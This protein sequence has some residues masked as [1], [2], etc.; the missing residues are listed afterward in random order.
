VRFY[1]LI[2]S[3][4][5]AAPVYA[6]LEVVRAFPKAH[7][8]DA[9]ID[10]PIRV[11]FDRP[12]N[13]DDLSFIRVWSDFSGELDGVYTLEA[14][15]RLA[16]FTP[17]DLLH[18]GEP[19]TVEISHH[20]RAAD[21]STMRPEGY[22]YRFCAISAPSTMEFEPEEVYSVRSDPDTLVRLYG[23]R[24]VDLNKDRRIDIL[25]VNEVS[26]DVR[27]LLNNPSPSGT[28]EPFIAPTNPTGSTPSPNI[29]G[30]FNDD[31]EIDFVTCNTGADTL[32]V[33]FGNGD[34]SFGSSI[35]LWVGNGPRGV[36]A[37]D[38]DGDNDTDIIA[39]ATAASHVAVLINT[40]SGNFAPAVTFDGG[41]NREFGLAGQDMNGDG[42]L[43][44]V[45]GIWTP[46]AV[47]VMLGNGDGTFTLHSVEEA[48]GEVWKVV[49]GDLNGDGNMD[50]ST[51]NGV[52]GTS[53]ILLGDGLGGLSLHQV[54]NSG[55]YTTATDLGDLDGDGD[56]DWI[57][58]DFGTGKWRLFENDGN[59]N[60]TLLRTFDAVSNPS[61]A[62]MFDIDNDGDLDLALMDELS[63]LIR[64]EF[65]RAPAKYT[66][67]GDG[68]L[69]TGCG[70]NNNTAAGGHRGCRNSTGEGALLLANGSASIA[71]N[72]LVV[73]A[74]DLPPGKVGLVLS[75]QA[76]GQLPLG[77]GVMCIGNP[78]QRLPVHFADGGGAFTHDDF[79]ASLIRTPGDRFLLQVVYRD[80]DANCVGTFNLTNAM[81][82]LFTP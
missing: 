45:L 59:A 15:G 26:S 4:L 40:G 77:N 36:A 17:T 20:L 35:D 19:I 71:A 41:G 54:V 21:G 50:V 62:V 2:A 8:V 16:I 60:F 32:T 66:C 9:P 1:S 57:V 38:V 30:D 55:G 46:Q 58:S 69:L 11:E 10:A 52:T 73:V 43:D 6:Q 82:V 13:P 47:S 14:G 18:A 12:L 44:L 65:A 33:L 37:F 34:G 3:L 80:P 27:V 78:L 29:A 79:G 42:I 24:A 31:G 76:I 53:A 70:C 63:D 74:T 51:A 68:T 5:I 22:A 67:F 49:C 64:L 56:L 48:G 28:F 23:A 61:C 7:V 25:A 39:T 75:S 72:D 81:E